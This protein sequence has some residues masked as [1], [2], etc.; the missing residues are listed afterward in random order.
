MLDEKIRGTAFVF[1]R[2]DIDTDLIIPARYLTTSEKS[3]LAF[4]AFEPLREDFKFLKE[5]NF[6]KIG[7]GNSAEKNLPVDESEFK[8][9]LIFTGK[10]FGCGSSREH[11]VW[12]LQGARAGAVF[13]KSFARIFF[14]N[15]VNNGFLALEFSE[16]SKIKTGDKIEFDLQ[17]SVLK[18]FSTDAEFKL[19]KLPDFILKIRKKGGLLETL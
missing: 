1:D 10:N 18:N 4:Y 16:I 5:N 9:P 14:R 6:L 17:N 11:A 13:A 15:A 3:E 2:D 7:A 12:A 19:K 8:T